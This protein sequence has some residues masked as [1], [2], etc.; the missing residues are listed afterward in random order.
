MAILPVTPDDIEFFTTLINPSRSY[1]SSSSGVTGSLRLFARSSHSEKEV[2]PLSNFSNSYLNDQDIE[3]FRNSVVKS[4]KATPVGGEFSSSM[5]DYLLKVNNQAVSEKKK[6]K[7]NILRFTPSVSFTSNTIRKLNVKD[8]LMSHYGASY[9]TAQWGYTNYHTLNFFKS[10][11]VPTSSVL[12]YPNVENKNL[13]PHDG[14]VTGSY[15]LSGAF[16]FDFY[17]N[18]RHKL[19]G[20]D[21]SYFKAG[22]IFHM[23]SSYCLSLVT[24]SRKD[25]NGL[26]ASFRL[27][28]QLSHSADIPPSRAVKGTYPNDLVFLS[29]DNSL[30]WNTWNRIVVRW[31]TNI[32]NDGSGSFNINGVDKGFF[33][34]PSGTISPKSFSSKDDPSVLCVGNYYEGSNA[35]DESQACFFT[36]ISAP[37]EGLNQLV[38]TGGSLDQPNVYSFNHQLNAEL[39]DLV[40]RRHY[41]TD[42]EISKSFG[43]GIGSVD[44]DIAFFLPPF[45][46]EKSPIR[47]YTNAPSLGG[48]PYGGVLQT[49]F[50][51]IDGSTDDPFNVA[52]SFGVNGHYINIENFTKDFANDVFPRAHHM[53]AS[54]ISY[55]TEAKPAND[56]LYEDPFVRRRNLLIL[57]CDDGKFFPNYSLISNSVGEKHYDTFG[58][59]NPSFISLENLLK[60]SSLLFGSTH[61]Y[62]YDSTFV[63]QQI[64]FSPEN[65]GLEPGAAIIN[66]K[67][68]IEATISTNE[69]DYGPGVQRDVPLTIYQRTKDSS[70]NQVTFFDISNLYYG[71]RILPGSFQL[72]D[73]GMS[74]SA[75]RISITLKDDGFGNIYRAD[76]LTEHCTWNSVGN[77]FYN[78]GIVAV[79]SPHLY[80]FGKDQ[81]EL[82]FKGEYQLHTSKYEILAP[83]GLLN[84][85]SNPTFA[86]VEGYVSASADINDNDK[87][88]YISNLNFHDENLNVVAKAVLAQPVLKREGEKLLFKVAFDF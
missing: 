59:F 82:S 75:G 72:T 11:S 52:M 50:F 37:R 38:D 70:S 1:S 41:M 7:I 44:D 19:D 22:T 29:D 87:F 80:L 20:T 32:T 60:T 34:V 18:P 24:G 71:S 13:P 67:N 26:P 77:I 14:H 65:P 57:P 53:S 68:Q 66:K 86:K 79:K 74:G 23:S 33:V 81:Y 78:E 61:D 47:K 15:S 69:S 35:G 39:H 2:R 58:R 21:A 45:F 63:D 10:P 40:I 5:N 43:R 56:F 48:E 25:E 27:Q 83:S 51:E 31:G 36:D 85:S 30:D 42:T 73:V 84:S 16:S 46:T 88:V 17:I 55:T 4:A 76:S 62:E 64:G 8:I 49:P 12:L 28:L 9:P 6:K 3:L 54:A